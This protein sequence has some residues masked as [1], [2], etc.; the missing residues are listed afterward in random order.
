M[1]QSRLRTGGAQGRRVGD[2][3]ETLSCFDKCWNVLVPIRMAIAIP[4]V[5]LSLLL[6]ISLTITVVDK[7]KN[8]PCGASCGYTLGKSQIL[9]PIDEAFK[10]LAKVFP[11]DCIFF[12]GLV[13]YIFLAAVSGVVGLGVRFFMFKLYSIQKGRTLPNAYMLAAWIFQV[14]W[15]MRD[16]IQSQCRFRDRMLTRSFAVSSL[17]S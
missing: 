9:N 14:S 11:I 12:G 3:P 16:A 10:G 6:I 8:S 13:M 1:R 7:F 17:S 2:E 4:L 15:Y 5:L